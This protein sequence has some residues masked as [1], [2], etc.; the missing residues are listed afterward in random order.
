MSS[1]KETAVEAESVPERA[2][3]RPRDERADR[4]ILEAARRLIAEVG[5]DGFRTADLAARAGV[6]KG[7]IYRRYGSKDE[8][9]TAAIASLVSEEI[10]VPDTGTTRGDL[11][12]L[13]R[14]A[15]EVYRGPGA[16]RLMPNLVGA[17]AKKPELARAVREGF[18]A[19]RRAAL[20]EVLARGVERGDLRP[21]LDVE[22]ALDVLGGPLFYRLL[23]TGGPIDE[24]LAEGVADLVLRGF[25]PGPAKSTKTRREGRK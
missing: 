21:D 14:E 6:G 23:I 10:V 2:L 9:V 5:V 17:M 18:L 11:L 22:L 8:L 16:G 4:A 20:S 7:A 12:V 13:M 19:G 25:A 15:V 1:I 24:R 3:G